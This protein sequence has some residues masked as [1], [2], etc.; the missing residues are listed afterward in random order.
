MRHFGIKVYGVRTPII[1]KGDD[2]AE[3]AAASF[4][5]AVRAE[6]ITVKESDI[7]GITEA[8]VAKAQGNFASIDDIAADV[9]AKFGGGDVGVVFPIISRNR[10]L[11]ILKGISRGAAKVY[12]LLSY[13][14]DEVGNPVMDAEAAF[15]VEEKLG[16]LMKAKDFR[17]I[18]GD[19]I[20]PFTGIDY[21]KE[22]GQ[23]GDNVEVYLSNDC[24]DI[25]KLTNNV[26]VSDI[27]TRH[28]TKKRI[29][30]AVGACPPGQEPKVPSRAARVFTLADIL[31]KPVNGSGFND[32]YGVLGSN[33]STDET[34]KLYPRDCEALVA[35]VR[36]KIYNS[37]G[38]MIEALV[39]GDGAF[40][41]PACGI[42]ELADPVVSPA[43]TE[44][45]E[46]RP[47]EVKIKYLAD[48]NFAGLSGSEKD[49]AVKKML[50]NKDG[51][52]AL[53]TTPRKYA[54][55]IGSLCDLASGSGDKGTPLVYIQGYF[56]NYADE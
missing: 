19:Y 51:A 7:L 1:N 30:N 17:D 5:E 20:H 40:K 8:V 39:Y 6:N 41:D 25:L 56:D 37:T 47:N 43:Y 36:Q 14:F 38:V 48:N 49:E 13:P 55:L 50:K 44:R 42:W 31:A 4:L 9:R 34:L 12:V 52:Y 46:G 3:I 11:S 2:F 26:L 16:G 45:L 18:C 29:K 23:A 32:M 54:D 28:I 33:V 21:I 35:A 10:F 22:Y 53:G 24:R 27:H 15:D